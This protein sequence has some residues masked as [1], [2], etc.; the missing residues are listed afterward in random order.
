MISRKGRLTQQRRKEHET[1]KHGEKGY[2]VKSKIL[3]VLSKKDNLPAQF[4]PLPLCCL[5]FPVPLTQ[6]PVYACPCVF[7]SFP[8]ET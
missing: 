4:L 5:G 2:T 3:D 6:L 1:Q 8:L 7:E